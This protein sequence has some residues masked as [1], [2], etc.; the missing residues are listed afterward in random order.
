[1]TRTRP[2]E[3]KTVTITYDLFDLSTAQHKA[4]LAGLLLQIDSMINRNPNGLTPQV[5]EKTSTTATI[6]FMSET[7]QSLMDSMYDAKAVEIRGKQKWANAKETKPSEEM[8]EEI[9]EKGKNGEVTKKKVKT[10]YFFHEQVQPTGHFLKQYLPV[11]DPQKDWHKLWRDMLWAVPR[12]NP[13]SREGFEQRAK[14]EPCREGAAAWSDLLKADAQRRRNSFQTSA[15]AG[16]LWLGAQAINA[17]GVAFEGRVEQTLLLHFWPLVAQVFVPAVLKVERKDG[18]IEVKSEFVGYVLAIPEVSDLTQFL[19]DY[20]DMLG[21]LKPAIRGFRP[22]DSVIDLPAEGALSFLAHLGTQKAATSGIRHSVGSVEY[23]HQVKIGNNIK[24]QAAGR[25]AIRPDLIED[26][27]LIVAQ[28]ANP[29]FRRSL[30]LALLDGK[31]WFQPFGKLFAEW[32]VSFFIPTEAPPK[33]SWFWIDAKAKLQEVIN[34]MPTDPSPGAMKPDADDQLMMLIHRITRTYLTERAKKKSGI[35]PEKFK[36]GDK[37]A[38]DKLPKDFYDARRSAGESLF[39]EFRS[40]RDQAFIQHF[41]QT[42][43]ATKQYVSEDHYTE[44]GRALLNRTEDVK[45]LTLMAL[46]ANS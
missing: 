32:D 23:L 45:T 14:G 27:E 28:Y 2:Q 9:E 18:K 29:L 41:S 17:E 26:Y 25:V 34:N 22:A 38:W 11:M 31:P 35:D 10:K 15:V 20:K 6:E 1:M 40:R 30:M 3:P 12:G 24:T 8:E 43:F 5:V 13:Q 37:I 36:D 44:I 4:G 16:S 7:V 33:L 21:L 19:L 46:S 42:F 39:L